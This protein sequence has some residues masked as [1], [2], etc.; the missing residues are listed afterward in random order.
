LHLPA[1]LCDQALRQW[2]AGQTPH[3]NR[4]P[5]SAY[6]RDRAGLLKALRLRW[7][8]PIEA[9]VGV[10]GPFNEAPRLPFQIG[11]A[12]RRTAGFLI[13]APR[14]LRAA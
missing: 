11:D 8:N 1:K 9:T 4:T 14:L 7:P 10:K 2:S 3:G 6:L 13:N 12:L 5:M